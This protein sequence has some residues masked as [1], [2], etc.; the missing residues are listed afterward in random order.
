MTNHI[1]DF[2]HQVAQQRDY[3][4]KFAQLQLRNA[5]L[6]ED[7]VSETLLAALSK[8][9]GFQGKSQLKTWLV[10]ILKFKII[11][12]LRLQGRE[13]LSHAED[14]QGDHLDDDL[15]RLNFKANGHHAAPPNDW[16][17]EAAQPDGALEQKQFFHV[18]E[19]CIENLPPV[20]GRV[21]MMREWL[22]LSV[23]EMCKELALT[24]TNLYVQLHRARLK[25]RECLDIKWFNKR[26][27][28]PRGNLS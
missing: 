7:V 5:S 15:D 11:D 9:D 10:G 17:S 19:L 6:A 14:G 26:C 2:A 20:Q 4:L 12:A 1:D 28:Q 27:A 3:L 23:E 25:M 24:S 8:P 13:V 21:F 18:L 22:E 16:A